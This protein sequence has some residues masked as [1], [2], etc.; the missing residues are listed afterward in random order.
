M[1]RLISWNF[2]REIYLEQIRRIFNFYFSVKL[3]SRK[4]LYRQTTI[5]AL[6]FRENKMNTYYYL[7]NWRFDEFFGDCIKKPNSNHFHAI[8]IS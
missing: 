1:K 5:K 6:I 8:C 2:F 7:Q 3:N 4:Q